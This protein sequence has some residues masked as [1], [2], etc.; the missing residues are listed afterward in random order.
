MTGHPDS[1]RNALTQLTAV[2][3]YARAFARLLQD[4]DTAWSDIER[5]I[6]RES[7]AA[8]R[9]ALDLADLQITYCTSL[10][11][12]EIAAFLDGQAEP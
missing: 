8:A 7:L 6:A 12:A 11:D 5:Y 10:S 3:H 2:R 4:S 9:A 1:F